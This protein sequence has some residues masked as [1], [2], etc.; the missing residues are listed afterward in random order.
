MR[1]GQLFVLSIVV[2]SRAIICRQTHLATGRHKSGSSSGRACQ[3]GPVEPNMEDQTIS[4]QPIKH[5]ELSNS[6][7][8]ASYLNGLFAFV[9]ILA[10]LFANGLEILAL[11]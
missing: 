1:R 2:L 5:S 9:I 11:N 6:S 4:D 10:C 3:V 7:T 8:D